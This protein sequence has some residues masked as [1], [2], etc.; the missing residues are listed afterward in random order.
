MTSPSEITPGRADQSGEIKELR[1]AMIED[2]H[3]FL[4]VKGRYSEQ[5][6]AGDA[7]PAVSDA[8][9]SSLMASAYSYVLAAVLERAEA[10]DAAMAFKLAG[11]A[12]AVLDGGGEEGI[13]ADV[14][15]SGAEASEVTP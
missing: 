5:Q 13:C 15:P 7:T 4:A 2:H 14:W 12:S 6:W 1:R 8:Y 3:R 11:F 9:L 10:L